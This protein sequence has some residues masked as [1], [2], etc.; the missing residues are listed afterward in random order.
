MSFKGDITIWFMTRRILL[1]FICYPNERCLALYKHEVTD[2]KRLILQM[3]CRPCPIKLI[4][5]FFDLHHRPLVLKYM[6]IIKFLAQQ[7]LMN[8]VQL[9]TLRPIMPSQWRDEGV[10]VF[11]MDLIGKHCRPNPYLEIISFNF[12]Y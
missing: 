10:L 1:R 12:N 9:V 7:G 11:S 6:Y 8:N 5:S 4:T 2:L 3:S